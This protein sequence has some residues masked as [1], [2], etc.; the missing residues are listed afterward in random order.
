MGGRVELEGLSL[1]KRSC[2]SATSYR[3]RC[4]LISPRLAL[5]Q[6]KRRDRGAE[7]FY[8]LSS[9][10]LQRQF[11]SHSVALLI[12]TEP[13]IFDI[14]L[15]QSTQIIVAEGTRVDGFKLDQVVLLLVNDGWLGMRS[16]S[17]IL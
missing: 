15:R 11:F 14:D 8:I 6:F 12:S 3:S 13:G 16:T 2:I 9:C 4:R 10:L 7:G 1:L 5:L 17:I